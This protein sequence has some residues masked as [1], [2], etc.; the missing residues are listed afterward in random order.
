MPIDAEVV[1]D[2]SL[3]FASADPACDLLAT[4]ARL[5]SHA[6]AEDGCL[7]TFVP[8]CSRCG[9]VGGMGA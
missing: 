7:S 2:L 6:R 3:T 4:C 9:D 5:L 8:A 1:A